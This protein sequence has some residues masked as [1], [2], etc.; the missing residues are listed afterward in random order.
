ML[1]VLARGVKARPLAGRGALGI[2]GSSRSVFN[3]MFEAMAKRARDDADGMDIMVGGEPIFLTG[4][5]LK[6]SLKVI[7]NSHANHR[8][9]TEGEV[10][11]TRR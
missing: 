9:I 6:A 8:H 2:L 10:C 11:S 7:G 1:R 5:T 3:G 4:D